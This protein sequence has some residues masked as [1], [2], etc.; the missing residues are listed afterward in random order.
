MPP[1]R[2][3]EHPMDMIVPANRTV[4][5]VCVGEGYGF[6]EVNWFRVRRGNVRTLRGKSMVNTTVIEDSITSTLTIPRLNDNDGKDDYRCNYNNI[7]GQTSSKD[8]TLTI[9]C[10]CLC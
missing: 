9:D 8:A 2:I 6:V 7:G 5:F 10:K 4:I 1:P 3:I